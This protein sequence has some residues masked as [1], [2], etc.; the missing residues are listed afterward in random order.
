[1]ESKKTCSKCGKEKP[2]REFSRHR[3]MADG[4]Q[5]NCMKCTSITT[6]KWNLAR[7]RVAAS[8]CCEHAAELLVL[9]ECIKDVLNASDDIWVAI[10]ALRVALEPT[11]PEM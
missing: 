7:K 2:L 5:S 8:K 10:S 4:L 6:K 1:M 9:Q 11:I 3:A